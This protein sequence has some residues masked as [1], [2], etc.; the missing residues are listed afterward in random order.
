MAPLQLGVGVQGATECISKKAKEWM[1]SRVP[2][3]HALMLLDFSNAF[4]SLDR[5]AMLQAISDLR[6]QFFHPAARSEWLFR[7]PTGYTAG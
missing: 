6:P 2:A 5:S 7:I 4:N 1:H 3:D